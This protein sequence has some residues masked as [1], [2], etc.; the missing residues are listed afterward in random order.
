MASLVSWI[1]VWELKYTRFQRR[2]RVRVSHA[3]LVSRPIGF[4]YFIGI[5]WLL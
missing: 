2:V 5:F 4:K 3:G 1:L